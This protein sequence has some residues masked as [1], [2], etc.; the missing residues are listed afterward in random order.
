MDP[1]PGIGKAPQPLEGSPLPDPRGSEC[2]VGGDPGAAPTP[3]LHTP[4]L[5]R[6]LTSPGAPGAG[7]PALAG[8]AGP[9]GRGG[10]GGSCWL[11]RAICL[12]SRSTSRWDS[13]SSRSKSRTW[14][15]WGPSWGERTGRG[16]R[17]NPCTPHAIPSGARPPPCWRG[18][19]AR[20]RAHSPMH[21][22][23]VIGACVYR[24]MLPLA[25]VQTFTVIHLLGTHSVPSTVLNALKTSLHTSARYLWIPTARHTGIQPEA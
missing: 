11:R 14:S 6:A 10:G 25:R 3:H 9:G 23:L 24:R 19:D 12:C 20:E 17:P 21:T 5:A 4:A 2:G 15:H 22:C 18:F 13:R 8:A 16:V 7:A 1:A